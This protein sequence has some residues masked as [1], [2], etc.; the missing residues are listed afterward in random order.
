MSNPVIKITSIY[1]K[2]CQCIDWAY[3]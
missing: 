2:L 3:L 1:R